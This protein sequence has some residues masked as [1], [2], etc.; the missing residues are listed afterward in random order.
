[1]NKKI[2]TLILAALALLLLTGLAF[3]EGYNREFKQNEL[4]PVKG[5]MYVEDGQEAAGLF[6]Q[7]P[8]VS[9]PKGAYRFQLRYMAQAEGSSVA[10]YTD[11][12]GD[13]PVYAHPLPAAPEEGETCESPSIIPE[14]A[15]SP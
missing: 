13:L 15:L 10:L 9:L 4:G 3:T 6:S 2:S 14:M 1:M 5:S 11:E 12:T 7:G 8:C